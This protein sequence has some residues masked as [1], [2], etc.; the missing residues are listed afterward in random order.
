MKKLFEL[1]NKDVKYVIGLMSGTSLDGVDVAI[2]EIE[3]NWIETRI[4]LLGFI[5]HPFPDGV[6]SVILRNS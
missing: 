6:K 5:E 2:V 4:N 1:S 3:N